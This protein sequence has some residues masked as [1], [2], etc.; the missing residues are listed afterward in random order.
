[1]A[2]PP[3][4]GLSLTQSRGWEAVFRV[5]AVGAEGGRRRCGRSGGS[6]SRPCVPEAQAHR[7]EVLTSLVAE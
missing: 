5:L 3:V 2:D 7:P 4:A 6:W 1:M